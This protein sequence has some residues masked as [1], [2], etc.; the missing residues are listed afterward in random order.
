MTHWIYP[1]ILLILLSFFGFIL[2][3]SGG[4][5]GICNKIYQQI[6]IIQGMLC[7]S[8]LPLCAKNRSATRYLG[9]FYH[10]K[11]FCIYLSFF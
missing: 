1:S 4:L 7:N 11:L 6:I 9:L 3:P 10:P 2:Y 5:T 8:A